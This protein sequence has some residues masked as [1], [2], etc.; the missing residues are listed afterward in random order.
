M[1][2][3][4]GLTSPLGMDGME[5]QMRLACTV[6]LVHSSTFDNYFSLFVPDLEAPES[7]R[8]I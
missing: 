2:S 4:N 5:D 1:S 7:S 6:I 8:K 3:S